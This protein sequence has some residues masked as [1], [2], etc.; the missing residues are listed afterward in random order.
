MIP[1]NS[2]DEKRDLFMLISLVFLS[3]NENKKLVK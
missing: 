1:T 2:A 3:D